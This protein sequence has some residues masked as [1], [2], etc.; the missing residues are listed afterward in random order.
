MGSAPIYHPPTPPFYDCKKMHTTSSLFMLR[1]PSPFANPYI[2]MCYNALG[3]ISCVHL[4]QDGLGVHHMTH[5][6]WSVA[7]AIAW[8]ESHTL[9]HSVLNTY[10]VLYLRSGMRHNRP[11]G[12]YQALRNHF[13][14]IRQ[15]NYST[16]STPAQR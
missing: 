16:K 5:T 7:Q 10:I 6:V 12:P 4:H 9:W 3:L 8:K 13:S 2:T 11:P 1:T 15:F 14:F